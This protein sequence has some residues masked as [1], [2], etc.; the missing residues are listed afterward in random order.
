LRN[1]KLPSLVYRR[2]RGD[3]IQLYKILHGLE[4]IPENSLLK[5]AC[6]GITRGHSLKLKKPSHRTTFRQH[7]S[8]LRVIKD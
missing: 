6:E 3:M 1:L 7:S 8:S 2:R 5:L 4:D